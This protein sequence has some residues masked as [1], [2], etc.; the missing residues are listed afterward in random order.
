MLSK[1]FL[2][3][4]L[5]IP[6]L[7]LPTPDTAPLPIKDVTT[8]SNTVAPFFPPFTT[9]ANVT[10]EP[11]SQQLLSSDIFAVTLDAILALAYLPP[12]ETPDNNQTFRSPTVQL[13]YNTTSNRINTIWLLYKALDDIATASA[14]QAGGFT[15]TDSKSKT[16]LS[17]ITYGP[18]TAPPPLVNVATA[19]RLRAR[20]I[21][22]NSPLSNYRSSFSAN[23]TG[24]PSPA[25]NAR[26]YLSVASLIAQIANAPDKTQLADSLA[27]TAYPNLR[28]Q[29]VR[30]Q[31]QDNLLTYTGSLDLLA[32]AIKEGNGKDGKGALSLRQDW[33]DGPTVKATWTLNYQN[34]PE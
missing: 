17:T 4:A 7:S 18:A 25:L 34:V 2:T 33:R 10:N 23:W 19:N 26:F 15:L 5:A 11:S 27:A 32:E 16:V 12:D 29:N 9:G 28:I 8:H 3:L 14:Y 30:I 21:P 13:T 24:T 6:A 31:G 20:A 1:S 22:P